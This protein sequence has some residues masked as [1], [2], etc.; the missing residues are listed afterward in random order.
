MST[1]SNI[2]GKFD[3]SS[4]RIFEGKVAK[5]V[6]DVGEMARVTLPAFS[7][8]LKWEAPWMPRAVAGGTVDMPQKGDR[9]IVALAETEEPGTPEAWIIGW[10]PDG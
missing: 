3:E 2:L 5:N 8:E 4:V 6:S 1:W 9:C 10:W 7:D